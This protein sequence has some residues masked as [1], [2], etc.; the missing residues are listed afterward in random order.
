MWRQ[1]RPWVL[2]T[3]NPGAVARPDTPPPIATC[4]ICLLEFSLLGVP[5]ASVPTETAPHVSALRLFCGHLFCV[6]C[7]GRVLATSESPACPMCRRPLF[8]ER[9]RERRAH[10]L[11][12][13]AVPEGGTDVEVGKWMCVKLEWE[14]EPATDCEDCD[15]GEDLDD[16]EVYDEGEMEVEDFVEDGEGEDVVMGELVEEEEEISEEE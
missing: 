16:G 3:A 15:E 6:D 14:E 8:A 13:W 11:T 4:E 12:P 1:V 10:C 7:W 9:C 2:S 5:P